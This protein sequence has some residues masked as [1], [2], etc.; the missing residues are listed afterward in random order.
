MVTTK[1]T[2]GRQGW[3]SLPEEKGASQGWYCDSIQ[4]A[5]ET[6]EDRLQ[7]STLGVSRDES[8]A[9]EQEFG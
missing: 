8:K 9:T 3:S 4:P 6:C 7:R 2:R 5:T 1:A